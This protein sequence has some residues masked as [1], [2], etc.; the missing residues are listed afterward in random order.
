[1]AIIITHSTVATG[2]DAGNGEVRKSQWNANH[3]VSGVG[4]IFAQSGNAQTVGAVTTETTLA[5]I[6]FAG[7]EVGANGI[8]AVLTQWN[9]TNGANNKSIRIRVG[10][11]AGTAM[12]DVSNTTSNGVNRVTYIINNNS[13]SAQKTVQPSGNANGNGQF[14][15]TGPT[16]TVNTAAAWDLVITGQKASAGDTLTLEAYQVIVFKSA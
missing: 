6:S 4:D 7:G 1:M 13:A 16:A 10:G 2:T 12:M 14:T 9:M 11:A 5:T 3:T 15:S 8:I